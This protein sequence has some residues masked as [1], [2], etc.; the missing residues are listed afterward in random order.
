MTI[1][2]LTSPG[3]P[4]TWAAL[5]HRA[6][7]EADVVRV[8]REFV[9]QVSPEEFARLPEAFRPGRFRDAQDISDF[10]LVVKLHHLAPHETGQ[11]PGL[12][13]RIATF[14]AAA[15]ERVAEVIQVEEPEEGRSA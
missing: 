1:H 10:A 14:F 12:E 3:L 15:A 4:T 2:A 11:E 7:T 5:L 6:R 13:A 8:V 9:A